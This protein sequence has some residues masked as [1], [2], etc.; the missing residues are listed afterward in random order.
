MFV[1]CLGFAYILNQKTNSSIERGKVNLWS[2]GIKVSIVEI[3]EDRRKRE[4]EEKNEK[5]K[6]KCNF[7]LPTGGIELVL[8]LFGHGMLAF[9][10]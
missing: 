3:T 6:L 2:P 10:V 1:C 9:G 8:K 4:I 5:L 7:F